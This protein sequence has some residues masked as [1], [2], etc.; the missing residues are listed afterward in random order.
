MKSL[1]T[2]KEVATIL[3]VTTGTIRNLEKRGLLVPS[4]RIN[5]RPRYT[6]EAIQV[7]TKTASNGNN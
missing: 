2:R 6:E 7:I 5:G 3:K 1:L 4:T